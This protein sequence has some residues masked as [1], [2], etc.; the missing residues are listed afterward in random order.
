[1][2]EWHNQRR[3]RADETLDSHFERDTWNSNDFF[4]L[5][6]QVQCDDILFMDSGS[7]NPGMVLV[8]MPA[9]KE[10][11]SVD[12]QKPADGFPEACASFRF[13]AVDNEFF[14]VISQ[15]TVDF[16]NLCIGPSRGQFLKQFRTI[17]VSAK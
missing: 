2:T 15:G 16:L 1:M 8:S 6:A 17:F 12:I 13:S 10:E 4:F 11:G 7:D 5:A 9:G 14:R 3:V